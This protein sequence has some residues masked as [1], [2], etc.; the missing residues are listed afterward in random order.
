[1][2]IISWKKQKK[3]YPSSKNVKDVIKKEKVRR[4][5]GNCALRSTPNFS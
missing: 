1:M 4:I 3:K 2:R 5:V